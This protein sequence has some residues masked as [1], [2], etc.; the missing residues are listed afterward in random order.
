[1]TS[2]ITKYAFRKDSKDVALDILGNEII[3]AYPN[4]TAVRAYIKAIAPHQGKEK[5]TDKGIGKKSGLINVGRPKFG[6]T[7]M[8]ITTEREGTYS[9]VTLRGIVMQD[10]G[11]EIEGPGNC[12]K[13][14]GIDRGLDGLDVE[15]D[16]LYITDKKDPDYDSAKVRGPLSWK[17]RPAN[18]EG[19]YTY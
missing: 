16:F 6:Q 7:L 14:L 2:R 10:S 19:F 18:C 17:T 1:M 3:R 15:N 8:D 12:S 4:G 9:C 13:A 11:E 5:S